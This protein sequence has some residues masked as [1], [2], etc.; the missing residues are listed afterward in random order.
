[1]YSR[2]LVDEDVRVEHRRHGSFTA[3]GADDDT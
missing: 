1:M 3:N 2:A